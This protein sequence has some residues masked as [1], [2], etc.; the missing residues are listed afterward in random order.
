LSRHEGFFGKPPIYPTKNHHLD[1]KVKQREARMGS[2][3]LRSKFASKKVE[4]LC[5]N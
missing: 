1:K 5:E 4:N 3:L 2:S